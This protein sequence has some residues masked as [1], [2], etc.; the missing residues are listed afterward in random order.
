MWLVD[1]W[2]CGGGCA[3]RQLRVHG[4]RAR[5]EPERGG[6]AGVAGLGGA[7]GGGGGGR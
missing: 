1:L 5:A 7:G 2:G 6:P 3:L 4:R